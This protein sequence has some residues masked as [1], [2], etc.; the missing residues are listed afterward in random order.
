MS[1]QPPLFPDF[2]SDPAGT[3]T[4]PLAVIELGTS[5][6]RMA[7][8][9]TDGTNGV[10]SVE[11]LVQGV[12]LGKDTFTRGEIQRN[13]QQQCVDVLKTYRRKLE[14]YQCTNPRHIRVVATSAVREAQ[15]RMAFLDRI[16]TA[17]GFNVETIDD[18]EI[19]RVT[20]LTMRPVLQSHPRLRDATT[21]LMEVGG[22][23]TDVLILQGKDI[24]HSQ[25]WRL[26]ALRLQEML[27]IYKTGHGQS[28]DIMTG[29][30]ERVLEQIHDNVPRGQPVELVALGGDVRFA[31]RE[32]QRDLN[33]S[34]IVRLPVDELSRLSRAMRDQTV[35]QIALKYHVELSQAETL[36]PALMTNVLAAQMLGVSDVLVTPFNLRDALLN[37]LLRSSEWTEE[38]CEQVTH[39][40][41][42]FARRYHVDIAH[43][44]HVARLSQQLF[45]GLQDIHQLD[46]RCET[47]LYVAAL[48]HETGQY[49]SQNAYHKHSYYL[50]SH[51]ELF[52]LSDIDQQMVA[53]ISRYHRR[54]LPKP[55][56]EP[57][58]RLPRKNRVTVSRLSA[59]LRLAVGLDHGRNQ[60][61]HDIECRPERQRLVIS[62]PVS[63]GDL[64]LEE[65]TLRRESSLFRDVFGMGVLLRQKNR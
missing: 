14:E 9:V 13:T 16:F 10:Q 1:N 8:G 32:L 19:A 57:Y 34:P 28:V 15:N 58:A 50:V 31:A 21:M 48:L 53:L 44:E 17:T 33:Q 20:Y 23:N 3:S 43:A 46:L 11:Q 26:G 56:H 2:A 30:I 60:R 7:I 51:G 59:I 25:S 40:A 29:Q 49:V 65:Q 55:S 24:L 39:S 5:A 35:D 41:R 63:V 62:V 61:I 27:K 52:G 54:A 64:S 36:V 42:E 4:F 45:R 38:F 47:M 12:S 6:I 22:G 18:A 37:T